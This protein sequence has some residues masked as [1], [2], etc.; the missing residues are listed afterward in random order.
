MDILKTVLQ[1][2]KNGKSSTCILFS[3]HIML[4]ELEVIFCI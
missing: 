4:I 1:V 3:V 2:Y